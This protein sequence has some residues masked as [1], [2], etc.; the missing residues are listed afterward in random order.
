MSYD[1]VVFDP[2]AAPRDREA[3]LQWFD[4]LESSEEPRDSDDPE[5][6]TPALKTWFRKIIKK[7]PPLNGPLARG[8][9]DNPKATDYS[10]LHS[11]I[12]AAF[13]WPEAAA[14]YKLVKSSAAA[15]HLGFYDISGAAGDIWWPVPDWKLSSEARGEIPLPLDLTF[16][17][18]LD[19]LD[20]QRN[21]FYLLE[22]VSGRYIQCGG[23]T[24]TCTVEYRIQLSRKKHTHVV[25]GHAHGSDAPATIQMSGGVVDVQQGEVLT[26]AEAAELFALF[27]AAESFP[28]QYKLRELAI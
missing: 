24:S 12:H 22:H 28:A 18:V 6:L 20:P 26:A 16:G 19:G 2:S 25:V 5:V 23:S 1:L 15:H 13:G 3:F 14:A 17:S 8:A 9:V 11:I 27:F 10:L 4:A 7:Y 21:S